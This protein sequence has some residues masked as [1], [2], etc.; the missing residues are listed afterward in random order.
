MTADPQIPTLRHTARPAR[1]VGW[2]SRAVE[3][4]GRGGEVSADPLTSNL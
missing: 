3:G 1:C 2:W 4:E